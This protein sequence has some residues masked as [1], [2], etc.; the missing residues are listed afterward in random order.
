MAYKSIGR[1][2][3]CSRALAR[4]ILLTLTLITASSFSAEPPWPSEPIPVSPREGVIGALWLKVNHPDWRWEGKAGEGVSLPL[5]VVRRW[6]SLGFGFTAD[7]EGAQAVLTRPY[8]LAIGDY[9]QLVLRVSPP[10]D[11]LTS[12]VARIDGEERTIIDK[13]PPDLVE[14]ELTGPISGKRLE[15][16]D[17]IFTVQKPGRV[18]ASVTWILLEKPD[19]PGYVPPERPFDGMLAEPE[20]AVFEPGLGLAIRAEDMPRL[21]ELAGSPLFAEVW[22]QDVALAEEQF[23]HDPRKQLRRASMYTRRHCRIR[24]WEAVDIT[25]NGLALALVGLVSENPEYMRQAAKYTIAL[26]HVEHWEEG[27]THWFPIQQQYHG[28]F[29]PNVATLEASFLLDWTWHWLS[30]EGRAF[31]RTSIRNKGL[32]GIRRGLDAIA[33]QSIR[34]HRGLI[35]GTLAVAES[36]DDPALN[37]EVMTYLEAL[38]AR[39]ENTAIWPDGTFVEGMAYG[40]GTLGTTI[41]AWQAIHNRLGVPYED[42]QSQR[43]VP[44]IQFMLEMEREVPTLFA[45]WA[46][47]PLGSDLFADQCVPSRLTAGSEPWAHSTSSNAV[48][49]AAFG[50]DWLWAPKFH[51]DPPAPALPP[52]SV[53][54]EGGWVFLGSQNPALPQ[55]S[56]ETGVWLGGHTW[57]RK[58]SIALEAWGEILLLRRNILPYNDARHMATRRTAAYNTFTPGER[59][60][61]IQGKKGTGAKLLAA[62][63]LGGFAF[64]ESDAATAWD[65]G[66][67]R[68]VRRV[69]LIRPN[70]LVIHDSAQLDKPE[71][72]VQNWNSL[73]EWEIGPDGN[74]RTQV[75]DVRALV[76]RVYPPEVAVN[77]GPDYVHRLL[78]SRIDREGMES[79]DREV[80][81]YRGTFTN[82]A[83]KGHAM[84]TVV[85]AESPGV[86]TALN[87]VKILGNNTGLEICVG[88]DSGNV[89]RVIHYPRQRSQDDLLGCQTDGNLLVVQ[90]AGGEMQAVVVF[91]ARKLTLPNGETLTRETP[92]AL[93]WGRDTELGD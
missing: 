45:A 28:S 10:P 11:T 36:P 64:V 16:I 56:V 3:G 83:A 91:D 29:G 81:V 25:R 53:F 40:K 18:S 77:A 7:R 51:A 84:L 61:Q 21:R 1:F 5:S 35:Q 93:S 34:Y 59:P 44:A 55:V 67:K 50:A 48:E 39:L 73:G 13:T 14:M 76:Q 8:E 68:A 47:G 62:E 33:N 38:N 2:T 20:S 30:P 70:T 71:T 86:S 9:T 87:E 57:P 72:G 6:N 24:E 60:Q 46:A 92:G 90:V 43:V 82:Q 80:P 54:S 65:R 88:G 19:V 85:Q 52:F 42:I 12:L 41:M 32:P 26:A 15:R 17:I 22:E 58:N 31:V 74:L 23:R 37:E 79:P 69:I 49:Y 66:V 75:G 89:V 4:A 27:F 63:D 78:G